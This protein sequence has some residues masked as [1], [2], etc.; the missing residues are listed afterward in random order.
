MTIINGLA[1]K[2]RWVTHLGC[3]EGCLK[4]LKRKITTGWLYG[5]TGH[6]FILNIAKDLC[7][8]GPTAWRTSMLY[9]LAPNLGYIIDGV[10]ALRKNPAFPREQEKAWEHVKVSIDND[11][12]CYGWELE[13]PE[14]YVINGYNDI[15]YFYS[16][17]GHDEGTGPRL[18]SDVGN[19][20][21]G[22]LEIYSIHSAETANPVKAIKESFERVLYHASNPSD[23]IFPNYRSG[24]A[25]YDWWIEAIENGSALS[26]GHSYNAAVWSECRK[27]AVEF[28]K[29][30]KRYVESDVKKLLDEARTSYEISAYNLEH[31]HKTYPFTPK[32]EQVLLGIDDRTH[33]TVQ[34]LRSARNAEKNGLAVLKSLVDIL[35]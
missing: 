9:E 35:H 22:I 7:P 12:P 20:Q 31:I 1:W 11:I 3:I 14:F 33:H 5:G 19:S 26:M 27:Y 25:G 29:E 13:I 21:I 6:A 8:S 34:L 17:P 28:L 4:Y 23:L 30:A 24:L 2:P 15:G 16:G 10:F 18:W 32:L